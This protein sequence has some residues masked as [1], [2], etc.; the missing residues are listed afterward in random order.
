VMATSV[1]QCP[2]LDDHAGE[3]RGGIGRKAIAP[4][5]PAPVADAWVT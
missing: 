3:A 4:V 1:A 2:E 5:E